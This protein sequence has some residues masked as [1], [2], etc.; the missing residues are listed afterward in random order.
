MALKPHSDVL[1]S[2]FTTGGW[3]TLMPNGKITYVKW[4]FL[5]H[6]MQFCFVFGVEFNINKGVLCV[7][8]TTH[9]VLK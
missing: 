1:R 5:R 4:P 3:V 6:E 2:M 8:Y 7:K 9:H